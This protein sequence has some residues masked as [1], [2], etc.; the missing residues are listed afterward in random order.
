MLSQLKQSNKLLKERL[1]ELRKETTKA[2]DDIGGHADKDK[3]G[4]LAPS[5]QY[6]AA[7]SR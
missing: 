3:P 4:R 1:K 7:A 5:Q 6:E 2:Y